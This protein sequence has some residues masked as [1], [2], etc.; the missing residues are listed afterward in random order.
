MLLRCVSLLPQSTAQ[1]WRV[2]KKLVAQGCVHLACARSLPDLSGPS[3]AAARLAGSGLPSAAAAGGPARAG[4]AAVP[5]GAAPAPAP[6]GLIRVQAH[7][8]VHPPSEVRAAP[9]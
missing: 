7:V 4:S 5:G 1:Q 2:A 6:T 8:T 3:A 9:L